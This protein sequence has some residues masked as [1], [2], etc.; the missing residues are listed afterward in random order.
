MGNPLRSATLIIGK[1][2]V[3]ESFS[4]SVVRNIL[5]SSRHR[6]FTSAN[7]TEVSSD[8]SSQV[9]LM[10]EDPA[11]GKRMAE[12]L[13]AHTINVLTRVRNQESQIATKDFQESMQ[14]KVV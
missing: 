11:T 3:V 10:V 14:D 13:D 2:N 12:T 7:K 4:W 8:S 9:T 5:P 6:G 1:P